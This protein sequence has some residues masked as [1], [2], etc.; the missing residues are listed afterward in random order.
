M[1]AEWANTQSDVYAVGQ[2]ME[3]FMEETPDDVNVTSWKKLTILYSQCTAEDAAR[4][5]ALQEVKSRF[6]MIIGQKNT[7][8]MDHLLRRMEVYAAN[9]ENVVHTRTVE[10]QKEKELT[11]HLLLQML[12][13]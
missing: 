10:L 4:R 2:L 8:V 13:R 11:E 5:P 9:L 3:F 12:P 6:Q 1:L 7:L